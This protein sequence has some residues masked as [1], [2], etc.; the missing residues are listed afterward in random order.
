MAARRPARRRTNRR[1][2]PRL[3]LGSTALCGALLIAAIQTWPIPATAAGALGATVLV[4]RAVRTRSRPARRTRPR[5][6]PRRIPTPRASLSARGARTL[7]GFQTMTPDHFEHAVAA[8]AQQHPAVRSATVQGGTG[9]RGVDVLATFHDGRRI[10][11]QCK[12]YATGNNIGG[13]IVREVAGSVMASGCTA[14]VI[15]TTAGFTREA[16][17]TNTILGLTLVDGPALVTW[18]NTGHAPWQ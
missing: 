11:I 1:R 12:R 3:T 2:L 17:A 7:A 13:P 14:G 10:L 5:T 6:G 18:A 8:L 4:T 16:L 9:D 15:V